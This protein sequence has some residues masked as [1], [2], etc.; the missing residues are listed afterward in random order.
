MWKVALLAL[1]AHGLRLPAAPRR[2]RTALRS[3][4]LEAAADGEGEGLRRGQRVVDAA[5]GAAKG[6]KSVPAR[7]NKARTPGPRR[8]ALLVEPTPFTHVSGYAN[9]F[10]EQLKYLKEFGDDVAIAVPDDKPEA[11][12]S[13][14]G[15]PITTV[16]GFRFPLYAHLCLTGDIRGQAKRMVE[17]FKPDV[18]HASSPGFFALA[19]VSY[20][21]ALDVP[22]VL[23]YHTHLPVYAEKY[24]GWL[25]S[26]ASA[27]GRDQ[28]G[29]LVRRPDAVTSPQIMAEFKEQNIKRVG[30]WRKGIDADTFNPDFRDEATRRVLAEPRADED[31]ALV[32]AS[33]AYASADLFTMPSDSETLGFVVLEA[34][35]SGLPIVAANAGGIPSIKVGAIL[36]DADLRDRLTSRGRRD[37]E[38]WSWK[39]STKHLRNV[40]YTARSAATLPPQ[41]GD[42]PPSS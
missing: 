32:G 10:K 22:L 31:P 20:A 41:R 4:A 34:M 35:A 24:A 28:D 42:L 8:V 29:A 23:S 12:D 39:A 27:R 33:P 7:L 5:G 16:D 18:I 36:D 3:S 11:P 40:H 19:A 2:A 21:K 6:V 38:N 13:Y 17:R 14:D 30:V 1:A 37:T 9:R 25:P 15:F 26:A